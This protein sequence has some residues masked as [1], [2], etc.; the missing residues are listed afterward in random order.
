M[1]HVGHSC[2]EKV[3]GTQNS[4]EL[5]T[6]DN[7]ECVSIVAFIDQRFFCTV[8]NF[9]KSLQIVSLFQFLLSTFL[10]SMIFSYERVSRPR[11]IFMPCKL[12][13]TR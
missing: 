9:R 8:N 4:T 7:K 2:V 1:Y 10:M 12:Q 13:L 5:C 11:R 3:I 6:N